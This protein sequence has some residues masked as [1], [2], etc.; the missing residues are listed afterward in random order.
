VVTFASA[1]LVL[2][3]GSTLLSIA[4]GETLYLLLHGR[5]DPLV[6]NA[7][8]M[9]AASR[10]RD[11]VLTFLGLVLLLLALDV[12]SRLSLDAEGRDRLLLF[13]CAGG[14]VALLF[15]AV[16]RFRPFDPLLPWSALQRR[17]GTFTD[18]NAL[19]VGIGLLVPLLLAGLPARGAPS[20]GARRAAAIAGLLAAPVALESSG[21]RT[22]LLLLA[23]SAL[24]AGVG[25]LRARRASPLALAAALAV[26]AG[27]GVLAARFLPRGGAIAS[28]GLASRLGAAVSA[29]SFADFAN[30]RVTF[31]RTAF[32]MTADEPLSG[33]GLAGFP[34][35]F[36]AAYA[37]RH[38]PIGVTDGATNALLDV[39]AECGLPGLLLALLAV[40][41]LL[42]RAFDEAFARGPSDP[43]CRA[44]GAALAGL[45]VACQTG[46][47]T[48]FVEIGLLTSLAAA[49]LLV[50][51]RSA[52]DDRPAVREGWRPARTAGI[53][54]GAGLLGAAFAALPTAR[55]GAP[56]RTSLWAGVYP[57]DPGESLHWASRRA[58]R[59]I[60][61]A[62]TSVS[63]RLQNARP[64]GAPVTVRADVLG[65]RESSESIVLE[66]GETRDVR[67]DVP[68]GGEVLRLTTATDFVPR[69]LEGGRDARHLA[70][71]V[72]GE[73]L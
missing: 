26:L 17:A 12:F 51:R 1:F 8:G 9:T 48:R 57:A 71:R 65:P 6:V 39:S 52:R 32:E 47:H 58:Y 35:E 40:V 28:G 66:G 53:L 29:R 22:G 44:S 68:P 31:W 61:P 62:E 25:L 11:A 10:T 43:A 64:D 38:G 23:A 27:G 56:F 30:H 45:F 18:P 49:F 59:E 7:L 3:A 73:G 24:A 41:P 14:A 15:A 19:G 20:D 50:P 33:I 34:Y 54:A 5:A 69:D 16:E 2:A 72:G 21:S 36:P 60:R 46:S 13:A 70:V 63:L 55:P 42:A 37:R 67:I 4:R